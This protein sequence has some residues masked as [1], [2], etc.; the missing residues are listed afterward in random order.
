MLNF[1][2]MTRPSLSEGLK[3]HTAREAWEA[4]DLTEEKFNRR[5]QQGILPAPT[6][7][8]THGVRFFDDAWLDAARAIVERER[9][10]SGN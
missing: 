10:R 4:L 7:I 6:H 5:L 8:N 3:Y 1:S 9:C 2:S